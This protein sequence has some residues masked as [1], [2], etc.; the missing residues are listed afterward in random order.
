MNGGHRGAPGARNPMLASC[1]LQKMCSWMLSCC[2]ALQVRE[3]H[4]EQPERWG[5]GER[6]G[7]LAGGR[8]PQGRGRILPGN[9]CMGLW[10]GCTGRGVGSGGHRLGGVSEHASA[11]RG[12]AQGAA[13]LGAAGSCDVPPRF[14]TQHLVVQ[15]SLLCIFHLLLLPTLPEESPHAQATSEL[16]ARSLFACGIS[17][18]LQTSLGSR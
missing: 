9:G 11:Q 16:L 5:D 2:L 1:S 17:T 12:W 8:A 10:P 13:V 14:L 7:V 4:S 6:A 3:D 15:A 18:V